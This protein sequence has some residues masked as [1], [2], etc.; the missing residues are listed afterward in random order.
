MRFCWNC[1]N[2]AED[3]KV[4]CEKCG[5]NMTVPPAQS[6]GGHTPPVAAQGIPPSQEPVSYHPA[7]SGNKNTLMFVATGI[8]VMALIA[9]GVFYGTEVGKLNEANANITEL[10]ANVANLES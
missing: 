2:Q 10:T 7:K 8:L 9:L 3:Y 4:L 6:P 1:G 5:A